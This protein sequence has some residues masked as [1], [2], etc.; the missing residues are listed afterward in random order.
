M[1]NV[2]YISNLTRDTY[3]LILAGGRGSR[4]HELTDWRAK[5]ALYFGGK[6]RIID[7]PL[8]NCINS[9]I[10]RVGVVTQYKS[11]SLIRHVS[12]GWGHFKKEL[13]ES[14]EILPASQQTS[15]N[16]YEGTADA[17][18]QNID[19][20]RHEIPKYVMI[21][22]GD[23][24]YRMDYAGLLAAHA[25]SGADMTVCCLETP[26]PEAAGSFGVMEVDEDK[27]VIG[28]EEKPELPK[29]IPGNEEFCLAS[30]GNYVFNT[31][32]LFDQLRKDADNANS[33]RDFGK[34]IIPAIIK[35]ANVFAFPFTS[36]VPDEPAYWRDVGTL[37][38]F[39]Q[40]NMELL[41]PTPALNLY[42]AKW[43]IWTYQEQL[44]PAK[45]VFDD[46]DRRGM[47]VDSIVSGGCIIS[48]AKVKRSVL[49][50]EVRVCSYSFVKD[51]VLLPDVVVLKNCRIQNAIIDRGCVIPEGMEIGY[52]REQ[53]LARGFR[54]S[55]KGI[56]LVTRKMLGLP[57]G[58]E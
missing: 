3:A 31:K 21:L 39:F 1:S 54:V 16:W 14:V 7:F 48:G 51:S 9:G 20:I 12:R 43:P 29:S 34:D 52:S 35:E 57:V 30:M 47:A 55:E 26:I 44:P 28:F 13:G 32:F 10:R 45:F 46:D 8:S 37:D 40:A 58:Y 41:S 24:V 25:E 56:T 2:R 27:R 38:S 22:S 36:A 18:F 19:I 23:H 50:D 53:D 5:P 17:V 49:F 11:H 4:L 15:G 42:D 6:F 33:D